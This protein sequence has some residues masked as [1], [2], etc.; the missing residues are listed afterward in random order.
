MNFTI[1][2]ESDFNE[3]FTT[4]CDLIKLDEKYQLTTQTEEQIDT[5]E[6]VLSKSEEKRLKHLS[7]HVLQIIKYMVSDEPRLN[8]NQFLQAQYFEA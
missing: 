6:M 5:T 1:E 3:Y 7:Q 2:V 8:F 4:L